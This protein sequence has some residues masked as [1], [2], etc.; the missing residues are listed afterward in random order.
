LAQSH[1]QSSRDHSVEEGNRYVANWNAFALQTED[2]SKAMMSS[3]KKTKAI[4]PNL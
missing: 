2:L 4:Y 1:S 3:L